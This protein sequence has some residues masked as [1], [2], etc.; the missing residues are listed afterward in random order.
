MMGGI[1]PEILLSLPLCQPALLSLFE[2]AT[3]RVTV[4]FIGSDDVAML[5]SLC[6]YSYID[7]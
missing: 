5:Y 2:H 6:K 7:Y 1:S 4:S 3:A